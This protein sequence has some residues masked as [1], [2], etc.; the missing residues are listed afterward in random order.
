MAPY[1]PHEVFLWHF[2]RAYFVACVIGGLLVV[3]LLLVVV[4]AAAVQE[5]SQDP[6]ASGL[7]PLKTQ[8]C[9]IVKRGLQA[10]MMRA[11]TRVC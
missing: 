5:S 4:V 8:V 6:D 11:K 3:G 7:K 2:F 10:T 1:W 9:Q